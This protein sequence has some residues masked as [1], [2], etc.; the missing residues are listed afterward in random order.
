MF[1]VIFLLCV[2]PLSASSPRARSC[3]EFPCSESAMPARMPVHRHGATERAEIEASRQDHGSMETLRGTKGVPS[4]GVWTS[5]NMR[6]WT[7]KELGVKHGQTSG[8]L[9]PPFP[10][11]PLVP[12]RERAQNSGRKR[13]R[14]PG[15][16]YI[17]YIYTYIYIYT[18]NDNKHVDYIYIYIYI[19][20][21]TCIIHI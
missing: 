12:S 3:A 5:V 20:I 18:H 11:T 15:L 14:S 19:Y 10:G 8:Y 4:K 17:T 13:A 16:Y 7:C 21:H 9:R 2:G 6:V 1:Y